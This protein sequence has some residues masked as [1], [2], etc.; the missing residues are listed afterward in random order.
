MQAV[1]STNNGEITQY[2]ITPLTVHSLFK[3][4]YAFRDSLTDVVIQ[5]IIINQKIRLKC[6]E[7]VRNISL[8]KEKLAANLHDKILIY[9]S[10]TEDN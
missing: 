2:K 3:D 8:H 4:K 7:L 5:N 9:T 1:V 6:K 10:T